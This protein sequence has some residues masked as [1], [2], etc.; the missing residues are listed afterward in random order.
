[1]GFNLLS[2]RRAKDPVTG[3]TEKDLFVQFMLEKNPRFIQRLRE[4]E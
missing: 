4:L 1:L 2:K 3:F